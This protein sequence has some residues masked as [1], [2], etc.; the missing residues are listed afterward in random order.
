MPALVGVSECVWGG[1]R[2]REEEDVPGSEIRE[3]GVDGVA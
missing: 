3:G 2:R 1:E